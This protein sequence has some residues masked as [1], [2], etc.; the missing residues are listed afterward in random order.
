MNITVFDE[1]I[2]IYNK[3]GHPDMDEE[4]LTK[5]DRMLNEYNIKHAFALPTEKDSL[6]V[7]LIYTLFSRLY[8]SAKDET[9]AKTLIKVA[10]RYLNND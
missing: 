4:N 8:R 10:N 1:L 2:I 5:L 9:V 7:E 6:E 3:D